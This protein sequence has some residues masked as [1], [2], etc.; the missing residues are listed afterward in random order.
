MSTSTD[1]S[2]GSALFIEANSYTAQQFNQGLN[3]L[4]ARSV[5]GNLGAATAGL[6]G[7][8]N[9]GDLLVTA[10][11]SLVLS[12]AAGE[13]WISG[14]NTANQQ[15]LYYCFN[16][17]GSLQLTVPAA[18]ATNP[19]VYYVCAV[20]N[21]QTYSNNPTTLANNEWD[22]VL[23]GGTAA[24]TPGAPT[25]PYNALVLA[26][27]FQPANCSN[28]QTSGMICQGK[29][30][31]TSTTLTPPLGTPNGNTAYTAGGTG[32]GTAY[33]MPQTIGQPAGRF[34]VP[35]SATSLGTST[36][37]I[38]NTAADY[39]RGG[40]TYAS[41]GLTVPVAGIYACRFGIATGAQATGEQIVTCSLG[42]NGVS[43]VYSIGASQPVSV[44][45]EFS[46]TQWLNLAA[47]TVLTL[48]GHVQTTSCNAAASQTTAL[49]A[50]LVSW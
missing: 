32:T 34:Y 22:I 37:Q 36:T 15:G 3:S 39:L 18:N 24:A 46:D 40:M 45:I 25:I 44:G 12:I 26:T 14:S 10:T 8:V 11:T 4:L 17:G 23:V 43:N 47:G 38:V 28:I 48:W 19:T 5:G 33:G 9:P 7:I 20:V 35:T 50:V 27:I 13:C 2:P 49:S 21:D 16:S 1:V 31:W 42:I 41:N 30:T 6:G 29:G